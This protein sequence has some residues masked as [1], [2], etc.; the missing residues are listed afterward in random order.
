M[1]GMVAV[2]GGGVTAR[3]MKALG[4]FGGVQMTN[5]LFGILRVKFIALWLG[6]I[7]VGLFGIFNSA[8]EMLSTFSQLGMRQTAVRDISLHRNSPEIR[9]TVSVVRRWG[10]FLGLCGAALMIL[11]APLLSLK[12]FGNYGRTLSYMML[13]LAVFIAA[14]N[15]AEQAVMQGLDRL[16]NLAKSQAWSAVAAFILSLPLLYFFGENSIVPVILIYSLVIMI[17]VQCF[18]VRHMEASPRPGLRTTFIR[19]VGFIKLGFYMTISDAFNQLLNYVFIALLNNYGGDSEVGFY[20]AGYTII[21][22][23]AGILLLAV[24]VEY[25]PRLSAVSRS[26]WRLN[27]FVTHESKLLLLLLFPCVLMLLAFSRQI[28]MLLYSGEFSPTI[29]FVAISCVGVLLRGLS[30][31]MAYVMLA[32]GDGKIYMATEFLSIIITFVLNIIGYKLL[33]IAGLGVSYSLSYLLY[34]IS[35]YFVYRY[36]YGLKLPGKLMAMECFAVALTLTSVGIALTFGELWILIIAV[37]TTIICLRHL[38]KMIRSSVR[39]VR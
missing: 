34:I 12:T 22:R 38:Y 18:R 26:R 20:Q 24:S 29:P 4:V 7:G 32:R 13:S 15:G 25:Y 31:C 28:V 6:P 33:G 17:T 9:T 1:G 30:Y 39:N 5:I 16:R 27:T 36:R 14:V 37:P 8:V 11:L 2:K 3:V 35:I 19:G 21:N 10:L 23:Y